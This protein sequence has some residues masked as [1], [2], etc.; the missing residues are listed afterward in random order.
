MMFSKERPLFLS[1]LQSI[2]G[3]EKEVF[4]ECLSQLCN[5]NLWHDD[6]II[7]L[8]LSSAT[9]MWPFVFTLY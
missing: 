3:K 7:L 9:K 1:A 2:L 6:F 8:K 4:D 5:V